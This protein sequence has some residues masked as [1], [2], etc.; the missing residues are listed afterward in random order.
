M[1][2]CTLS[3]ILFVASA[4]VGLAQPAPGEEEVL[5]RILL[6]GESPRTSRR[7]AA[8]DK[9]VLEHKLAE[10]VEEYQRIIGEA[11]DD[12]VPLNGRHSVQAR[13]LC[14][15]RLA[16]L[17]VEGLR[18]YRARVDS[19][20]RKW[21]DLGIATHDIRVLNRLVEETFASRHTE[22]AIDLLGDLAFER[23][24]FEEAER[25]WRM[26]GRQ[27]SQHDKP[28]AKDDLA[29][30]DPQADIAGVRAKLLL[31]RLFRGERNGWW[32][33][34]QAFQKLHPKEQ[35]HLAGRDGNYA[36]ILET[37]WQQDAA[38][39]APDSEQAWSTFAGAPSRNFILPK[40]G[41][42]LARLP[43]QDGPLWKVRLDTGQR[44]PTNERE[45][46]AP[47][48]IPEPAKT[49][50]SLA[51]YPVLAGDQVF[52]ADARY[53]TCFDLLT[54]RRIFRYDLFGDGKTGAVNVK[55]PTEPDSTY[56]LTVNG[57]RLFA[58]MGAQTVGA[59]R[60]NSSNL[61]CLNLQPG[62]TGAV[63]RWFAKPG[64]SAAVFEGAPVYYQGR[65]IIAVTRAL[66]GQ[67]QTALACYD[68][69]TGALQWQ[70]DICETQELKEGEQR[71][72]HHL[73]TLDGS[74]VAYC[75]H[76]G[77]VVALDAATG[78][79][80]WAIRYPS[81]GPNKSKDEPSPRS[82]VPCLAAGG[83]LYVAP[84][85]YDRILCLDSDS[86]HTIWESPPL[87]VIHLL[88]VAK[89]HL[90]FTESFSSYPE[91]P[92]QRIRA[93][94]ADS[95]NSIREW[96]Q[97]A[98]G[99]GLTA[100]GRGLL[101]GECVYWPTAHGL[102]VLTQERGEPVLVDESI[103]GNLAAANGCLVV[104]GMEHL[105]AYVPESRLLEQREEEAAESPDS[106]LAHY[107]LGLAESE[108][109]LDSK[110][111]RDLAQAESLA[112]QDERWRGVSLRELA[113]QSRHAALL[114]GADRDEKTDWVDAISFLEKASDHEFP[115]PAR[116]QALDRFASLWIR[117]D[118]P[119][120]AA[121]I[122][123]GI[124]DDPALRRSKIVAGHGTRQS[125]GLVAAKKIEQLI[126]RHGR[127]IYA[128]EELRARLLMKNATGGD[129][130]KII[131][132][133]AQEI[134]N[135]SATATALLELA[136]CEEKADHPG[137]AADA[138]RQ[139]LRW[140]RDAQQR[141]PALAGL[142]LAYERQRC[143]DAARKTWRQLANDAGDRVVD[144]LD[145]ESP[146][147]DFVATRLRRPAYRTL[148]HSNQSG[149]PLPLG[150]L[151]NQFLAQESV[152]STI[153]EYIL[154]AHGCMLCCRNALAGKLCWQK[155]LP[156][157]CNWTGC[158]ADRVIAAG[159]TGV[160]A[161]RRE[162][163]ESLWSFVPDPLF[164][165]CGEI[166]EALSEFHLAD[167]RLF[168]L[169]GE[170]RLFGLDAENG[171]VLWALWAPGAR[172][173]LS[174]P[175]GRFHPHYLAGEKCLMVQTT[176]GRCL[177]LRSRDGRIL[178][179]F[180]TSKAP[181][182]Q[183][184]LALDDHRICLLNDLQHLI[185]VDGGA[186]KVMWSHT[187][188]RPVSL[189]GEAP[190]ARGNAQALL[191]LTS[192]NYGYF[193]ECLD[194]QNGTRRWRKECFLGVRPASLQGATVDD[195]AVY[196]VED[197]ALQARSLADGGLLWRRAL[198]ECRSRWE[199][200]RSGNYVAVF[201]ARTDNME[202][203]VHW[204]FGAAK[205]LL[206]AATTSEPTGYCPVLFCDT[207]TGQPVQRLNFPSPGP[208]ARITCAVQPGLA[209]V[210]LLRLS[211]AEEPLVNLWIASQNLVIS[212]KRHTWGFAAANWQ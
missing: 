121:L 91:P 194:A 169:Q 209:L 139:F 104:A 64:D 156:F 129:R 94:A 53:V 51:F 74:N 166:I 175:A 7:L 36:A 78:R 203:D 31:A 43:R 28:R 193:L 182:P 92:Q 143:W 145:R 185:V 100:F 134:P 191:V 200:A 82:L 40:A 55:L 5:S 30:P 72:R 25:W 212:L 38:L 75:S 154:S 119:I 83:R 70:R 60:G 90:I 123:Q 124:L 6:S 76:S 98:D 65:V 133:L 178:N 148:D 50:R 111:V 181:W 80:A 27:A 63:E 138:Y 109:G 204:L 174:A 52:V 26:L 137:A 8:A 97:P 126:Q 142:A 4:T 46:A 112:G 14:Q 151:W 113:R 127:A 9:L 150:R 89:G 160:C 146:V 188:E 202:L 11:G 45:P 34:L 69:D 149:P 10:A 207:K 77:A 153:D 23:G 147:A 125:A 58:R 71:H 47:L 141:L 1:F 68:A 118:R 198:P 18:L 184:P 87:E 13:R 110:A 88:G 19:Q 179:D 103:A 116:L 22:Q 177:V 2:R 16:A 105:S 35:G 93:L 24:D 157:P 102:R 66:V 135:A 37:I 21:L 114:A 42:S 144:L 152:V 122:W 155:T 62:P 190:Q 107:R 73:V 171:W 186:G 159:P 44:V 196:L 210:P 130:S 61:V 3:G 33:E 12:L 195:T 115:P 32:N 140:E 161:L 128:G 20:A 84:L 208:C 54:G 168:F 211:T 183:P 136:H 176:G 49:S 120:E 173:R 39:A 197:N 132:K 131:G 29:F 164:P 206:T 106:A 86:G 163:G 67:V 17:P 56:T 95:G 59:P 96:L 99:S 162:D 101:A 199:T 15:L 48:N 41:Q 180:A 205:L 79:R 158:D 117:A 187:I 85:D 172:L 201:P 165:E 167:S 81:R 192:R 189:S 170:R 57:D 108:A